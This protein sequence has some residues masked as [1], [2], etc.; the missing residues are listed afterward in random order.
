MSEDK[1]DEEEEDMVELDAVTHQPSKVERK[2]YVP[3]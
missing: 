2:D 3:L 1:V